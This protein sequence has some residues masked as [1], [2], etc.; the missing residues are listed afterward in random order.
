MVAK[1]HCSHFS[2]PEA[3]KGEHQHLPGSLAYHFCS[4]CYSRLLLY[5][6]YQSHLWQVSISPQW[7]SGEGEKQERDGSRENA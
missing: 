1:K 2:I 6:W 4:V 3:E 5:G 7:E